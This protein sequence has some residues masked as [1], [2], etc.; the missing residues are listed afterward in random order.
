MYSIIIA[1]LFYILAFWLLKKEWVKDPTARNVWSIL[2]AILSLV[3]G[4]AVTLV[5]LVAILL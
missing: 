4:V 2:S 1:I 5:W 3:M